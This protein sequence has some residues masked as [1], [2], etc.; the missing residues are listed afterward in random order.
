MFWRKAE[1]TNKVI[2][3]PGIER[4]LHPSASDDWRNGV[5][6]EFPS[7]FRARL[8]SITWEVLAENGDVPDEYMD[9]VAKFIDGD[10]AARIPMATIQD[11]VKLL[12][13][14]RVVAKRMF[15]EPEVVTTD[16]KAGQILDT[17]IE[18]GD[19]EYLW[20]TIGHGVQTLKRFH[21]QQ[22]PNLL[23]LVTEQILGQVAER[24]SGSE[25]PVGRTD[26][27]VE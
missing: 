4:E 24:D 15:I 12:R 17:D 5:V 20:I 14:M 9:A 1:P 19:L 27:G 7:G 13:F 18:K 26:S 6:M 23:A 25:A 10:D 22:T 11:R 16:P 2:E 3:M 8:R 21:P